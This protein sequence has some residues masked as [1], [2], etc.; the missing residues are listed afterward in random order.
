C[1]GLGISPKKIEKI[2][3]VAKAYTTRVGMGPFPTELKDDVGEKLRELGSEF[4]ATTGRPRRCGWF[5]AVLV[6]FATIINGIDEIVLTKLDVLSGFEKIKIGV[7]YK[8]NDKII[9]TYP[10]DSKLFSNCEVIYEEV[11]GWKEDISSVKRYKDLPK[12]TQKYIEKIEESIG[13]KIS[14]V[15]TGS[16]RDQTIEK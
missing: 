10:F 2:I 1:T 12:N 4:G 5:D 7:G 6:K 16:S 8:Y 11:D 13:I 14:K 15:S 3:G 9:N